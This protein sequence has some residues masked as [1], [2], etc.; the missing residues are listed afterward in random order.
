MSSQNSQTKFTAKPKA[1]ISNITK[2]EMKALHNLREYDSH[3]VCTADKGVAL[4][5]IDKDMYIVKCMA[6]LNDR[7]VYHEGTD[8][9]MSIH[10]KLVKQLLVLK[11][12][13]IKI[14]GSIHPTLP[15]R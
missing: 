11:N 5:I 1:M 7:K 13:W 12:H 2:E 8:Q 4:V 10:A 15:S 6:L 9:T 14:Q 3:M